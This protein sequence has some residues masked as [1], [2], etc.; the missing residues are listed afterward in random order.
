MFSGTSVYTVDPKGRVT[1]PQRFRDLLGDPFI[2]TKGLGGCLLAV[3]AD[4]WERVMSRFHNSVT[5]QRFYLA[6]AHQARAHQRTGRF[7]V[8]APLRE[9]AHVR[10]GADVAVVGIGE[11]VEVWDAARWDRLAKELPRGVTRQSAPFELSVGP[12]GDPGPFH[13]TRRNL[14]G[15][16]ILECGGEPDSASAVR[17]GELLDERPPQPGQEIILDV[18]CVS[19]LDAMLAGMRFQWPEERW[20]N[21]LIVAPESV[22]GFFDQYLGFSRPVFPNLEA[23]LWHV[24]E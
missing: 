2:L 12:D 19:R 9:F 1:M 15:I 18:R 6:A 13:V 24:A 3:S 7:L 23:A 14:L 10:P 22:Y 8:P 5:F 11:G 20:N 17:V 16:S 21:L 4:Q